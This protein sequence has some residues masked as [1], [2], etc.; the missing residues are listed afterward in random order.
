LLVG[1][2]I[3]AYSL[4]RKGKAFKSINF[5]PDKIHGFEWEGLSPIL[6]MGL[7]AQNTSNQSFTIYSIAGNAYSKEGSD[8]VYV[9]NISAFQPQVISPNSES[10]LRVNI[11]LSLIG[12]ANEIIEAVQYGDFTKTIVIKATA[13]IDQQ[14][15]PINQTLNIGLPV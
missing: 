4:I 11:K 5:F 10:I 8:L 2:G 13:N 12:V 6:V 9:G 15:I 3:I 1:G 7:G 14:Q